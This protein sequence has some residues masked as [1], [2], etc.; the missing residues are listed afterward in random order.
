MKD[1]DY[2]TANWNLAAN[3]NWIRISKPMLHNIGDRETI[4]LA[5][6][7]TLDHHH[8]NNP[9]FNGWFKAPV[10]ILFKHTSQLIDTQRRTLTKLVELGLITRKRMGI[11]AQNWFLLNHVKLHELLNKGYPEEVMNAKHNNKIRGNTISGEGESPYLYNK[12]Y[13]IDNNDKE[14]P[15]GNSTSRCY[16]DNCSVHSNGMEEVEQNP[17]H[18]I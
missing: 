14:L 18:R 11:P 7:I 15:I 13:S 3:G 17:L 1:F 9:K 12:N 16:G 6:L 8:R 4:M 2:A 10:R 5:E